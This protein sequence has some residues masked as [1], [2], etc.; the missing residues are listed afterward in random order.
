MACWI[1]TKSVHNQARSFSTSPWSSLRRNGVSAE[2]AARKA[3]VS[4][5]EYFGV[6]KL[7]FLVDSSISP[8]KRV[9]A[10]TPA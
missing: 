6:S 3:T 5:A 10:W 9:P 4:S 1:A 7:G 2:I 8:R